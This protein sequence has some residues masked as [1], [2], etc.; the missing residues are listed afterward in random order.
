MTALHH[1]EIHLKFSIFSQI[2]NLLIVA[3]NP[4]RDFQC[5]HTLKPQTITLSEQRIVML[6]NKPKSVIRII[7]SPY[8]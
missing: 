3:I 2:I 7:T 8:F 6:I 5:Y 1:Y 4:S